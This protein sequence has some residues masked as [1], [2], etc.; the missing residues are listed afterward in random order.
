MSPDGKFPVTKATIAMLFSKTCLFNYIY[1]SNNT[2]KATYRSHCECLYYSCQRHCGTEA[3]KVTQMQINFEML[4]G[5]G[6]Q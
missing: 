3:H 6:S 1:S 4:Q 5:C 2:N